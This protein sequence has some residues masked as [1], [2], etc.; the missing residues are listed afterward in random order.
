[1]EKVTVSSHTTIQCVYK[2]WY[3]GVNLNKDEIKNSNDLFYTQVYTATYEPLLANKL[4]ITDLFTA[5]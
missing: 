2:F 5:Y 1:M 3:E 4:P